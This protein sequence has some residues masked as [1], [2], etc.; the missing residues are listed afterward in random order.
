MGLEELTQLAKEVCAI[1]GH[2]ADMAASSRRTLS[3]LKG[4]EHNFTL[5]QEC[6]CE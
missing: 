2:F 3:D 4:A 1:K 6:V 5:G